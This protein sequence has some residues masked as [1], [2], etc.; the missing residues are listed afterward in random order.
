M[1]TSASISR[2]P[3]MKSGALFVLGI[4]IPNVHPTSLVNLNI[5]RK[6]LLVW[7]LN[8]KNIP[9]IRTGSIRRDE[10]QMDIKMRAGL[11]N[12]L[13]SNILPVVHE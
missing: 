6:F 5:E 12:L 11:V 8:I 13:P 10:I 7:R 4:Q 9:D 2:V 1:K 3:R